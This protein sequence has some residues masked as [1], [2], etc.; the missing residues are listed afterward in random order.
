MDSM[1]MAPSG[2]GRASLAHKRPDENPPQTPPARDLPR[3]RFALM[4]EDAGMR[5][6][7][8]A[9]MAGAG[10]PAAYQRPVCRAGCGGEFLGAPRRGRPAGGKND[11]ESLGFNHL[12]RSNYGQNYFLRKP[13]FR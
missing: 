10:N 3:F 5:A 8:I 9:A 13:S 11:H 7:A 2:L 12:Y 4:T 6:I 1:G